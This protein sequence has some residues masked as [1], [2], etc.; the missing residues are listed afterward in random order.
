MARMTVVKRCS[1]CEQVKRPEEFGK[2]RSY[3]KACHSQ[4][5]RD[6]YER[7]R[8]SRKAQ[9][10]AWAR[11]NRDKVRASVKKNYHKHREHRREY[12][13][14]WYAELRADPE[15][16]AATSER[17][18]AN[19][20]RRRAHM[21]SAPSSPYSRTAIF[22]RDGWRCH[23]CGRKV[24]VKDASIDHLVPISRG[25]SD[26][27]DNVSLA[28]VNCNKRRGAGRTDAQLLLIG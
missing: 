10:K 23:I 22:E 1:K 24:S 7:N 20:N 27:A 12:F 8:E 3:C 15:R 26:T 21:N 5:F 18:R 2:G 6:W 4:Y 17:L 13:R 28:H 25:G 11:A 9:T 14:R 16:W 19:A